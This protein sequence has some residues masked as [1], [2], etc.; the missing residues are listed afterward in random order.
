VRY[1]SGMVSYTHPT[2]RVIEHGGAIDGFLSHSRYYP[3]E[4]VTV[5]VLLNTAGPTG[6]ASIANDIGENLFGTPFLP[7]ENSY[8]GDLSRFAGEYRGAA[9]G[10]TLRVIIELEGDN[11]QATQ[12]TT[13]N[14]RDPQV[15][16]Y[17]EGNTFYSGNNL[18]YFDEDVNGEISRL[19]IDSLLNHYVLKSTH[20]P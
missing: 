18:F 17:L 14:T 10:T 11:L 7:E 19:R 2:G 12:S 3:D 6:P 13:S 15:I 5:V 1:A 9:R 4:D 16:S 8:A 20:A